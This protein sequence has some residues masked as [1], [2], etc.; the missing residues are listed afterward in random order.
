MEPTA[1]TRRLAA[2]LMADVVGYSRMMGEDEEATVATLRSRRAVFTTYIPKFRGRVVDAKGDAI[3]AEFNAVSDAVG[4]AVEIQREIAEQNEPLPEAR[5]MRFRIGINLGEVL[6]EGDEI[7]GDGVNVAARLESLAEPGGICI[8]RAA[9]DKAVGKLPVEYEYIGEKSVKNIAEPVRTYR[10][11]SKPGAAAHRV[12]R[13]SRLAERKG[14]LIGLGAST[15]IVVALVVGG[16]FYMWPSNEPAEK[17]AGSEEGHPLPAKPS[18]AVLPFVNM[19]DDSD[20]EYFSDG[21]TEDIITDLSQY[22]DVQVIARNSV[23]VY[24]N[25]PVDV[26]QVARELGVRYV[27]EGSVRI[28]EAGNRVRITAQ[29]V[30]AATGNHVWADKYDRTLDNIFD[31]Q[32]EITDKISVAL[33]VELLEGSLTQERRRS[34]HSAEAYRLFKRAN[35][36]FHQITFEA[37]T[38]AKELAQQVIDMDPDS[39]LGWMQLGYCYMYDLYFGWSQSTDRDWERAFELAKKALAA[40]EFSTEGHMLFAAL[41]V[42]RGEHDEGVARLERAVA[43]S[44]N[45]AD[46]VGDLGD[47]LTLSGRPDDGIVQLNKAIRLAPL[48]A[49]WMLANIGHAYFLTRQYDRAVVVLQR[50]IDLYPDYFLNYF[51]L[52][53]TYG[54][55]GR[56]EKARKTAAEVLRLFPTF[57]VEALFPWVLQHK[58]EAPLEHLRHGLRQAGLT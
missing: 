58:N 2:I 35:E 8:S 29:L 1:P 30:D 11:L 44:P 39:A 15:A 24:K 36:L 57:S 28:S 47:M 19:S 45:N 32:D 4:C 25:K 46:A 3:M 21:L 52:S 40:D 56:E 6:V 23:M 48:P 18:I 17:T 33:D 26:R 12:V 51:W 27:L 9:N 34:A 50:G 54:E 10:V 20:L 55:M 31:L 41:L 16:V 49:N 7:Y 5:R 22:Q 38:K 43:F 37:N 13:A 42:F 14:K 53:A